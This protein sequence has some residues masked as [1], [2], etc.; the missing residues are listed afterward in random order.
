MGQPFVCVCSVYQHV[1]MTT[2]KQWLALIK[3]GLI[4]GLCE[5][6]IILITTCHIISCEIF[7]V[8]SVFD[9]FQW[10]EA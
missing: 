9:I 7:C 10:P 2:G 3:A 5:S 6:D 1:R 8:P 4:M